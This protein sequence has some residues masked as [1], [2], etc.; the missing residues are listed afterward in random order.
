MLFFLKNTVSLQ[1]L[2]NV[3]YPSRQGGLNSAFTGFKWNPRCP[4]TGNVIEEIRNP[5]ASF[6]ELLYRMNETFMGAE[7]T[8]A[9]PIVCQSDNHAGNF[10]ITQYSNFRSVGRSEDTPG[11]YKSTMKTV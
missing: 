3:E 7:V 5:T 10:D 1:Y 11:Y 8:H 6:M 4:Y 9:T 2:C